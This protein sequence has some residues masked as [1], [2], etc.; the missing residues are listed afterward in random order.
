MH[1][2]R[3]LLYEALG[4]SQEFQQVGSENETVWQGSSSKE[5]EKGERDSFGKGVRKPLAPTR[6]RLTQMAASGSQGSME[7]KES[8][9]TLPSG[10]HGYGSTKLYTSAPG[11]LGRLQHRPWLRQVGSSGA[12][13][14][15]LYSQSREIS[16]GLNRVKH[17]S[18]L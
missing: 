1:R 10:N 7:G 11:L 13:R 6:G 12:A 5:G 4:P 8:G 16:T 15:M 18:L 2:A 17:V 3:G 9:Y 14:L